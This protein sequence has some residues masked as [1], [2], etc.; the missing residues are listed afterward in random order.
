M[1]PAGSEMSLLNKGN[2]NQFDSVLFERVVKE[3]CFFFDWW[4]AITCCASVIL[5][6]ARHAGCSLQHH[7]G[8]L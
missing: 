6:S 8:E 1:S 2:D 4:P 5:V 3:I 7:D